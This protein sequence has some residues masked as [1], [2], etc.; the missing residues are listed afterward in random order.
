MS[1][2]LWIFPA[3]MVIIVFLSIP[4]IIKIALILAV[5]FVMFFLKR[6]TF[7][8]MSASRHIAQAATPAQTDW[9]KLQKALDMGL[10]EQMQITAASLY[11][12]K[13][14]WKKGWGLLNGVIDS[15]QKQ[16]DEKSHQGLVN[17]AK[18]MRSMAFWLNGDL[19][20]AIN[21]VSSV[22]QNGYRDK[23]LYINYQTYLLE[24][25]NLSMAKQLLDESKEME[26]GSLGIQDNHGWYLILSGKWEEA[27]AIYN[28]LFNLNPRFPEPYIHM[29]QIKLHYGLCKEALEFLSK[30]ED[31]RFTQTSSIK[32]GFIKELE[33]A[34]SEPKTRMATA[35]AVDADVVGVALGRMPKPCTET[36][37]ATDA[38]ILSGFAPVP[39]EATPAQDDDRL[40]DTDLSGDD[41]EYLKKHGLS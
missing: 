13:G 12:Q 21:E 1:K 18:I 30:A 24:K 31:A 11:I 17:V 37:E 32:P 28:V 19:D 22:Y 4:T 36:F 3:A 25:G 33:T 6:K 9:D 14:D 10:S 26:H 35:K 27:E 29:A 23:N 7:L 40:P 2:D 38:E 5:F 16:N 15:T 34:L 20:G 8:F 41:E 39:V